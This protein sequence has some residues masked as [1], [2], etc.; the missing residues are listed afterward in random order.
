[1]ASTTAFAGENL[2]R[3]VEIGALKSRL[4][5]SIHRLS[6]WL[7]TSGYRGY[8]TFD[9]LNARLVR[10]FTFETKLLRTVLQQGVRR[11]P[12][13]IRP[14]LGAQEIPFQQSDGFSCPRF[15]ASSRMTTGDQQLAG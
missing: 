9:G 11:F 14:L 7:E 12:L 10:P 5:E 1:M 15:Y 2:D 4:Y 13:N 6:D 8:D 3:K